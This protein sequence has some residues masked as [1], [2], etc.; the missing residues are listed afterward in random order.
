MGAKAILRLGTTSGPCWA[1][2]RKEH[3]MESQ[4]T[5]SVRETVI[6]MFRG[7]GANDTDIAGMT[8][9]LLIRDGHYRGRSFR[10]AR[11][12]A[13]WLENFVQFYDSDGEMLAT[14]SFSGETRRQ[15]ATSRL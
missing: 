5:E 4:V 2:H 7:Y 14:L 12:M 9:T 11:L 6:R 3:G 1:R 10:T 8:D 15:K 13:M